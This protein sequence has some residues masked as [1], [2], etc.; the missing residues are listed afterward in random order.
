LEHSSANLHGLD[1]L[2]VERVCHDDK[3]WACKRRMDCI[4]PAGGAWR[5]SLAGECSALHGRSVWQRCMEH[6]LALPRRHSQHP[7]WSKHSSANF[8]TGW[9]TLLSNQKGC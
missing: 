7:C 5:C 4:A 6:S 1:R 3:P 8:S 2:K 9:V